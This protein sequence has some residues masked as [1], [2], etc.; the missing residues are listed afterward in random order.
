[1]LPRRPMAAG[2]STSRPGYF[3][4]V[5]VIEPR[6]A[7]ATRLVELFSPSATRLC[8]TPAAS[9]PQRARS[10]AMVARLDRIEDLVGARTD[11]PT[12]RRW[13]LVQHSCPVPRD[14]M[15]ESTAASRV[16]RHAAWLAG[17]TLMLLLVVA[18]CGDSA[19]GRSLSTPSPTR[20]RPP[21]PPA[22]R[23]WEW[24]G[25]AS[26]VDGDAAST[27]APA[28]EPLTL[29]SSAIADNGTIPARY[30]CRADDV[31]PPLLWQGVP[32]GT[33]ELAVV[34]RDVD[35]E[36]FVHWVIAGLPPDGGAGRGHATCGRRRGRQRL[37]SPRVGR[38]V[39]AGGH[40]HLR[41]PGLRA[42]R[43][44]RRRGR[45]NPAATRPDGWRPARRWR[46][47]C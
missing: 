15:P 44:V 29:S 7:P 25:S 3:A 30:T 28:A 16:A 41:V 19:D 27:T 11:R 45:G 43:A 5:P 32:A 47:P 13:G 1:M 14:P 2:T 10:G 22:G 17:V 35:A 12:R 38:P 20:R 46:P 18:G 4:K 23:P 39:P 42:V 9:G 33:V 34:V 26:A 24:T 21:W 6:N 37:R 31:S 8:R 36:G 40:A